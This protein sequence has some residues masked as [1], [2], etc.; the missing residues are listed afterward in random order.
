VFGYLAILLS[1]VAIGLLSFGLW[2]HHM[3]VTGLPRL[4]DAF[5]MVASMTIAI[6]SG[7]QIFCWIATLWG[8]R[9]RFATPL[10]FV[11]GF[12][13]IFVIGGLTGVMVASIPIDTQVHDTYFVVAHF[14]YVLIGGAVFPLIGGV[15]YWFPKITGRM[16]D[17]GLGRLQFWLAFIGFN[18][19]FFPM[20]VLGLQ[21]MPR[22]VYTYGPEMQWDALNM[23]VSA[24]AVVFAVSFAVFAW[25]VFASRRSGA[26]A[27]DNPW[28]AGTLEW[29]TAS[30]PAPYNF[31][32][33]PFVTN[34]EPLWQERESLPVVTGLRVNRRE[35]IVT[36]V[37]DAAADM[38]DAS[39]QTSIWPFLGALATG[40][41]LIWS[42]FTPWAVVWGSVPIA[43][44]LI[45]W[46]WPKDTPED[47]S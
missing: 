44:T 47:D 40:A 6:P 22:R 4:A 11:L 34:R 33:I 35:L 31:A 23:L 8:G 9:P 17:E 25:N 42:I 26:I 16:M 30:P 38:R 24:G 46:F 45:G 29:A 10:L 36:T 41:T 14:H 1:L 13:F 32:R 12:F 15:Y 19:A 3:F 43:V 2:V 27:G 21:G 18:V 28:D 7:V 5:F 37:S 39:P 20:H